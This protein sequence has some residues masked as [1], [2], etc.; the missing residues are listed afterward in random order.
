MQ[1]MLGHVLALM[2]DSCPDKLPVQPVGHKPCIEESLKEW[3]DSPSALQ[4]IPFASRTLC[5]LMLM[6]WKSMGLSPNAGIIF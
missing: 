2:S 4:S 3:N 6:N 1:I 5:N